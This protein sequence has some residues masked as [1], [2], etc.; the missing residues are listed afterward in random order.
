[1]SR[2]EKNPELELY[3][4]VT[5]SVSECGWHSD[6]EFLVFPYLFELEDF[7]KGMS[8]IFGNL[9]YDDGGVEAHIMGDYA[10][11]DLAAMLAGEDIDLERVF[12]REKFKH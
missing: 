7:F 11:I 6:T 2:E 8:R 9:L 10:C 12:P 3:K 4:L 1:M 5:E